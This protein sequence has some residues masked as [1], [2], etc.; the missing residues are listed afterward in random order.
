MVLRSDEDKTYL[1]TVAAAIRFPI[2]PI[3]VPNYSDSC[4]RLSFEEIL[5]LRSEGG[6]M[7]F[8]NHYIIAATGHR[9]DKLGGY[10]STAQAVVYQF[11][12]YALKK[13][14]LQHPDLN[15]NV[16]VMSGMALGWD[17]AVALAAIS[18]GLPLIAAIPFVGQ[19]KKWPVPAQRIYQG[20]LQK[21]KEVVIVS[22]G[23]YEE[24][25]MLARNEYMVDRA[26]LML[27]LWSGEPGG[28]ANCIKSAKQ[29]GTP[30]INVWEE[31]LKFQEKA[32]P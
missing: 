32:Q 6:T 2:T 26:N 5:K 15:F 20:I 27:A 12:K 23:G 22:E 16:T 13:H 11:A 14:G 28:T 18:L 31:W 3:N 9:P 4:T 24:W 29:V 10:G 7:D 1:E 8:S 19:E 25:K 30:V 21:A 17:Q